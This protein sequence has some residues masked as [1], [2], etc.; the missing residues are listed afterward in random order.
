MLKVCHH[1]ASSVVCKLFI[2]YSSPESPGPLESNYRGMIFRW[3]KVFGADR[4]FTM[5]ARAMNEFL[6]GDISKL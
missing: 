5:A 4:T 2:F 1:V 3:Y 6:L